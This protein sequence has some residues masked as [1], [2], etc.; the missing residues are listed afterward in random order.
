MTPL[1]IVQHPDERLRRKATDLPLQ[2]LADHEFQKFLDRMI[3]TMFAAEGVGLAANQV[4]EHWN[5]A[6]VST[7]DGPL[8]LINPKIIRRSLRKETSEEGCLSVPGVWGEVSRSI[9]VK[10]TAY[11]RQGH[12]IDINAEGLFARIIQHEIDHLNGILI[13]D[14][15]K[16][17]REAGREKNNDL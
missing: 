3:E 7:K 17:V 9:L 8:V 13:I 10:V 12:K 15:A 5:L 14:K 1:P 6:V 16:N 4:G 2:R 11:D